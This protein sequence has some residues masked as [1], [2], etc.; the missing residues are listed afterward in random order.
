[1]KNIHPGTGVCYTRFLDAGFRL[2]LQSVSCIEVNRYSQLQSRSGE[3]LDVQTGSDSKQPQSE[4]VSE[5]TSEPQNCLKSAESRTP[6]SRPCREAP[7]SGSGETSNV[8]LGSNLKAEPDLRM[9]SPPVS[10]STLTETQKRPV[11]T[12]CPQPEPHS[13]S[14]EVQ[15]HQ[16]E[17]GSDQSIRSELNFQ[18]GLHPP[19]RPGSHQGE[20]PASRLKVVSTEQLLPEA[21]P[22][23]Q[24][25]LL[26]AQQ[27]GSGSRFIPLEV[28][29]QPRSVFLLRVKMPLHP[30]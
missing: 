1:M 5:A 3:Q 28:R 27:A 2:N 18:T 10:G 6:K 30:R 14:K 20:E 16:S 9:K 4:P 12:K 23:S 11:E 29:T 26:T 22:G 13:H 15:D 19:S 7:Q 24:V 21:R 25:R 8:H 17:P